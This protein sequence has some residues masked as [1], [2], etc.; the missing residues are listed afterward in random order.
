MKRGDEWKVGD[1][2]FMS[3]D[4]CSPTL[5]VAERLPGSLKLLVKGGC[6]SSD[7]TNCRKATLEDADERIR[8]Q[9]EAVNRECD[10]LLA[11]YAMR[12]KIAAAAKD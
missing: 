10:R 2:L 5:F 8:Y 3:G 6:Y 9:M 7:N 11:L 1:V 4:G 12:K